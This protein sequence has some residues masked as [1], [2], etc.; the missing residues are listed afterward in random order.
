MA[1]P[2][3][4]VFN[5]S[6]VLPDG[7]HIYSGSQEIFNGTTKTFAADIAATAGS[8]GT[9]ELA[10]QGVTMAK[11]VRDTDGKI[12]V[13]QTGAAPAYKTVSGDVTMSKEGVFAIGSGKV[14]SDMIAQGTVIAA[15]VLDNT[16][17]LAKLARQTDAAFIVGK[18]AGADVAAV[19]FS[20]DFTVSN[21]GVGTIANGAVTLLKMGPG[22]N[23]GAEGTGATGSGTAAITSTDAGH[24]HS[25]PAAT[26]AEGTGA[27]GSTTATNVATTL[28]ATDDL[29][30]PSAANATAIHAAFEG[31]AGSNNYPGPFS[32]PDVSRT[33]TVV[34]AGG[35]DGGNV[36][37]TGT[38]QFNAPATEIFN[39]NPGNTVKGVT[40]FKTV[41]SATKGAVGINPAAASIGSGDALGLLK[42]LAQPVGVL[43]MNQE[44]EAAKWDGAKST[45][46][47]KTNMPD[48]SRHFWAMYSSSVVITQNGHTHTGPSHTHA[49]TGPSGSGTASIT[50]TDAGHTHTGPSHVHAI[51]AA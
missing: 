47:P 34:F 19:T 39:S 44:N 37:V 25:L 5:R 26:D 29:G 46:L 43:S 28:T 30:V 3:G 8:I 4:K 23:T 22:I 49:I 42:A 38:D 20:G 16:L 50:S 17:T 7:A 10:D 51:T 6:I 9:A 18:G 31:N 2:V 36:T 14:T 15:D 32:N 45:V 1:K 48:G 21:L 27:S 11:M 33:L 41:T 35:W 40:A 24:T 12:M 13:A